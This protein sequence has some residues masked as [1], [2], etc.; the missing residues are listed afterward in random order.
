MVE[1]AGANIGFF[2]YQL[3]PDIRRL[4]RRLERLHFKI[5]K[6]KQSAVFNQTSLDNDLLPKYIYIYI[7]IFEIG[8]IL[9][10]RL[11]SSLDVKTSFLYHISCLTALMS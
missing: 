4:V 3:D 1:I 2:L 7:Y 10:L 11:G 5:L 6:K 9:F 8:F